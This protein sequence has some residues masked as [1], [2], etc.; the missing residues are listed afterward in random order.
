MFTRGRVNSRVTDR[1]SGVQ[2]K[3][4]LLRSYVEYT[5]LL[6]TAVGVPVHNNCV[7][8]YPYHA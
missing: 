7:Y 8:S 6:E 1:H 4:I 3:P 5:Y 2:T